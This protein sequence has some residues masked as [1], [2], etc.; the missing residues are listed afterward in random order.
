MDSARRQTWC[1]SCLSWSKSG[2][3]PLGNPWE[4]GKAH[5]EN[6]LRRGLHMWERQQP[7]SFVA[8]ASTSPD[9]GYIRNLQ[10]LKGSSTATTWSSAGWSS[11]GWGGAPGTC[12]SDWSGVWY[13][14]PGTCWDNNSRKSGGTRV[15]L[16]C[17]IAP[18][19]SRSV[20][21]RLWQGCHA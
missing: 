11:G 15:D 4:W 14:A 10:D 3:G 17:C 18:L 2:T 21:H 20:S 19:L 12:S 7:H 5:S 1:D 9:A 8:A 13:C 16:P 6:I